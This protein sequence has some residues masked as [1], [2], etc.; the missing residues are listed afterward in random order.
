MEL[1]TKQLT[2][3]WEAA[4]IAVRAAA[5]KALSLGVRVNIA[6]VDRSGIDIAFLRM[7]GAALHS[8]DVARDKAYTAASFGFPTKNWAE[9]LKSFSDEVQKGIIVRPRLVV[10]G[11][12]IPVVADGEIIG[13]I[14]VSGA[15]EEEDEI[16]ARAGIAALGL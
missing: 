7:P 14:G 15:S 16:C 1:C 9:L 5:D 2:I 6:V 11:G 8:M 10:F 4:H 12:G 3:H 13:A